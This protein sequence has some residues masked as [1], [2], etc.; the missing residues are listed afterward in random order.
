MSHPQTVGPEEPG[1]KGL[2]IRWGLTR[3]LSRHNER[4]LEGLDDVAGVRRQLCKLCKRARPGSYSA[5]KNR[6]A[7]SC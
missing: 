7:V 6:P 1:V 4:V 3:S 2:T 5:D